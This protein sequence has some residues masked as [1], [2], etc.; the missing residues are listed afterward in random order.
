M[1]RRY[2]SDGS[3]N[4]AASTTIL[5]LTSATTIR[6]ILYEIVFGSA[7]SPADQAFNMQVNR[8]TAAGTATAVTPQALDPGDP[9][10]LASAG[11]DHTAE[12]TYT[13]GAVMLSFSTNQQATFRW[14]VPPEQGIICPATASNGLGLRF[15]TI[16]G[17]NAKCEATFF[18]E[19]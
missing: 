16:S 7:A 19:E 14:V 2:A 5:G 18:H 3:Q 13:S 12:P 17:G 8:Y 11:E 4:A 15:V 9:A 6:P 10:S 1:A